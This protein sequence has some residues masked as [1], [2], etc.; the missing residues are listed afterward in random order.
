MS[1][2][3]SLPRD[4]ADT[5]ENLERLRLRLE[6]STLQTLEFLASGGQLGAGVNLEELMRLA[7]R[8]ATQLRE[9]LEQLVDDHPRPLEAA[10]RDLVGQARCI[11]EYEIALV[12]GPTDGSLQGLAV[13]DLVAAVR[14]ALTNVRCH[15]G[16]TRA[17]VFAEECDGHACVSI[18]DDGVGIDEH[19]L[20]P[21]LG[22]RHSIEKRL[23]QAGGGAS[24][25]SAAGAGML[26]VLR[27]GNGA[28]GHR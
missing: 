17:T 4:D 25:E 24:F 9:C 15:A 13:V 28:T 18:K 5:A 26:V 10:L 1:V 19:C 8:E 14:E 21:G 12:L 16:A 23:G 27:A 2:H 3:A 20:K 6:D 11:S 7:A 22:M